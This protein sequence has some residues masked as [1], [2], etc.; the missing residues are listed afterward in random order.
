MW[1]WSRRREWFRELIR[2]RTFKEFREYAMNKL[3][4]FAASLLVFAPLAITTLAQ[5]AQF[6][7]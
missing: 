3:F 1:P 2:T 6:T 4:A 5:A 7:A